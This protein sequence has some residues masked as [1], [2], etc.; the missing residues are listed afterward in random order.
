MSEPV[1]MPRARECALILAH[2]QTGGR[3][4][5]ATAPITAIQLLRAYQRAMELLEAAHKLHK[6]C[7][8]CDVVE[9][10]RAYR[11]GA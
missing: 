8:G 2:L 11:E 1:R 5:M 6:P 3:N 10:I 7:D 9:A 4:A